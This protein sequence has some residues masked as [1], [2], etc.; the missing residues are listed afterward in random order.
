M[1]KLVFKNFIKLNDEEKQ[2]ILNWRNSDRVRLKMNNQE[3]LPLENHI[4]WI[5]NLKNRK[6]CVYYMLYVNQ[7]PVGVID[8]TNI[9][10]QKECIAGSYIGNT[11]YLGFGIVQCYYSFLLAFEKL[12]LKKIYANVLKTNKRVYKM[13]K[14]LFNAIDIRQ[15]ENEYLIYWDKDIWKN[16]KNN[17]KT[18]IENIYE[19][20]MVDW[21]D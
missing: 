19:I 14:Q 20:E 21:I 1:Y 16:L 4:N 18:S 8:L 3:I 5:N 12:N 7:I 2:L 6:D 10:E 11:E 13:H 17:I 9:N 15:D